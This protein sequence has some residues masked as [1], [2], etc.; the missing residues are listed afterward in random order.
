MSN[1]NLILF[2]QIIQAHNITCTI[3]EKDFSNLYTADLELRFKL[4]SDCE[5]NDFREYLVRNCQPGYLLKV[6]DEFGLTS[7]MLCLHDSTKK[8][9]GSTPACSEPPAFRT[10]EQS[11]FLVV[12]PILQ[13][14]FAPSD[15]QKIL[16]RN[17][18]PD[19]LFKDLSAFY[20][21][22]PVPPGLKSLESAML[23]IAE[24]LFSG[25]YELKEPEGFSTLG[26]ESSSAF[27]RLNQDPRLAIASIEERYSLENR[28]LDM[29]STGNY[30]AAVRLFAQ[31]KN[32]RISPRHTNSLMNTKNLLI[33]F[34]TLCRKA[35]E[36]GNVHPVYIDDLSTRIGI[37]INDAHTTA[38]LEQME[39]EIIYKYCLLVRN[40]SMKN[41]S[42][43]TQRCVT[44][45]DFHYAEPLS[46]SFF[47]A[48]C[49]VT[50]SYL[51]TLF[52][53]ETGSN[54]TD[55]IHTVRIRHAL[56]LL[57]TTALPVHAVAASCGYQDINYFIK[58][59]KR[60]NGTSPKQY[61][62]RM[63]KY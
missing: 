41:Y 32:Y 49:H 53:K 8:E 22:V 47:A 28:L 12:G 33:I 60:L 34:N 48:M 24:N 36:R 40:Y 23:T 19:S 61:R 25:R 3:I 27:R 29:I 45:I 15:I 20:A 5:Y 43:I 17:K 2:Q 63:A 18:L 9:E 10:G 57:N 39:N 7:Y 52:K 26:F 46:L 6:T 44:Y 38:E 31:F 21:N 54:I 13:K 4:Y 51:S 58:I 35:V 11:V 16:V 50:K 56:M 37:L 30:N 1:E 42:Q 14:P 62:S 55:Y 59:F